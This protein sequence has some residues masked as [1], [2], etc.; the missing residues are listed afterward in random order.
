MAEAESE[1]RA[2]FADWL[3]NE[4][5]KYSRDFRKQYHRKASQNGFAA[6]CGVGN[7]VMSTWM[8]GVSLPTDDNIHFLEKTLG[9]G[10]WAAVGR[11]KPP[12]PEHNEKIQYVV[13]VLQKMSE[14]DLTAYLEDFKRR[15]PEENAAKTTIASPA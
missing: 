13:S 6:W 15:H 3:A 5:E 11:T 10:I 7:N 2:K 9:S 14:E 8:R 1:R 12:E 4:F